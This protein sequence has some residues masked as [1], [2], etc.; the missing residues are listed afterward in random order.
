[1]KP[2]SHAFLSGW[3]ALFILIGLHFAETVIGS[4]LWDFRGRL[5]LDDIAMAALTLLL[6]SGVVFTLAMRFTRTGYRELFQAAPASAAPMATRPKASTPKSSTAVPM[7]TPSGQRPGSFGSRLRSDPAA[8]L[9]QFAKGGSPSATQ[10]CSPASA[11]THGRRAVW[12]RRGAP[13]R[14]GSVASG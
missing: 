5:G 12:P 2:G 7:R 8:A 11:C 10:T 4:V 3:D 14:K 9:R 6:A 13:L 1:M